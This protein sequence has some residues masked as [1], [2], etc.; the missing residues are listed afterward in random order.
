VSSLALLLAL[1]V[2][3]AEEEEAALLA[4]VRRAMIPKSGEGFSYILV[5]SYAVSKCNLVVCRKIARRPKSLY[6]YFKQQEVQFGK[7]FTLALVAMGDVNASDGLEEDLSRVYSDRIYAKVAEIRSTSA[8]TDK[9]GPVPVGPKVLLSALEP[10]RSPRDVITIAD[11]SEDEPDNVTPNANK[12]VTNA[13]KPTSPAHPLVLLNSRDLYPALFQTP[14]SVSR[15]P[16][17]TTTYSKRTQS[18]A[19]TSSSAS[20]KHDVRAITHFYPP[21]VN[22]TS[23]VFSPISSSFSSSIHPMATRS[24]TSSVTS[25]TRSGGTSGERFSKYFS[26]AKLDSVEEVKAPSLKLGNK[27]KQDL[28][29]ALFT[30]PEDSLDSVVV[31]KGDLAKCADPGVFLNDTLIDFYLKYLQDKLLLSPSDT[32]TALPGDQ[33]NHSVHIFTSFLFTR[34]VNI[35]IQWVSFVRGLL[36]LFGLHCL[37]VIVTTR[38]GDTATAPSLAGPGGKYLEVLP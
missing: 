2:E 37:Y 32:S 33:G 4:F 23:D 7:P 36:G 27:S 25:T 12:A 19:S 28:G 29:V 21:L 11:E 35:L 24:G 17:T 3:A 9:Q 10:P 22:L 8:S 13:T 6:M 26:D 30:Y 20:K 34:M 15:L 38:P 18:L 5:S 1:C 31:T 14:S 16:S